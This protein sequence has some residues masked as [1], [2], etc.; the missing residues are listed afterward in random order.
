MTPD[1]RPPWAPFGTWNPALSTYPRLME[2]LGGLPGGHPLRVTV[3]EMHRR[4]EE[5]RRLP[6]GVGAVGRM[7][8]RLVLLM[9]GPEG[10]M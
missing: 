9:G 7:R 6:L 3:G 8:L 2:V 4:A 1:R 10:V 5:G